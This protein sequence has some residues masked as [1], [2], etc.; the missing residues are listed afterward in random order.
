MAPAPHRPVKT[1]HATLPI[2]DTD[3]ELCSAFERMIQPIVERAQAGDRA[4]RDEVFVAFEPKIRRFVRRVQLPLS[5]HGACGLWDRDDVYQEACLVFF[6]L[7]E[8]WPLAIPFGRYF[9][10]HFPWRL[11]DAVTR[12]V[13][14]R[15]VPPR[16]TVVSLDAPGM[17]D[18]IADDAGGDWEAW[19]LID[20]LASSLASPLDD[21]LRLH[22]L[23]GLTLVA[24]AERLGVSRR[25]VS[26]HWRTRGA[27]LHLIDGSED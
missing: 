11:R 3:A 19:V 25:T 27:D 5:P 23:D 6:R 24:T 22:V 1:Q 13:A 7:V 14:R 15:G 12:G 4:A 9:L 17:T 16:S 10:A 20:A 8:R 26:R 21:I 2:F 18:R